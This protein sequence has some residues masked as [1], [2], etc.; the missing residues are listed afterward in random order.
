MSRISQWCLRICVFT[1]FVGSMVFLPVLTAQEEETPTRPTTEELLPETTVVFV[2]I[3][4]IQDLVKKLEE[5]NV[6]RL[7]AEESIS[8]LYQDLYGQ[9]INA[10]DELTEENEVDLTAE[11]ILSL[12]HG[13]INIAVI[14][15][16]RQN[17]VFLFT[18]E[19]D[20]ENETV[21][22]VLD[23]AEAQAEEEGEE[24]ETEQVE[25]VEFIR[26]GDVTYFRKDG[27][28]VASNSRDE[29]EAYLARWQGR[30]VEKIR[31]LSKNRKFIKIMNRCQGTKS[32]PN[33]LRFYVDPIELARSSFRGNAG[34][35][36]GDQFLTGFGARWSLGS[37]RGNILVRG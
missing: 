21:D 5:S 20:T 18:F 2:E 29:L 36:I 11:E 9:A 22:K 26:L 15:P 19:F 30:E 14:A 34:A 25:E 8:P 23:L 3:R 24:I 7:L 4:D 6:G 17:P 35:Q 32:V 33:D 27:V 31:P 10:F 16:R 12:P 13:E 28:L 37:R 1:A